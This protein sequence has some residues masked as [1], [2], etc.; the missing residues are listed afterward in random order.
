MVAGDGPD[1]GTVLKRYRLGAGLT[2][3][4]LAER[5]HLSGRAITDLERGVRRA[6]RPDTV[7]LLAEALA[8]APQDRAAFEVAAR[9]H[10]V[11]LAETMAGEA[12]IPPPTTAPAHGGFLG[13]LPTGPLVGR[14]TELRRLLAALDTVADGQGR[15]LLLT[16][17]PGVGKTRLAQ[18]VM[19]QAGERGFRVLAGRCYEQ[20]TSLPFFPFVEALTTGMASASPILHQETPRRFAYLGRLLPDLLES[21]PVREGEDVRLR[22][23]YAVGGFLAALAAEAP[24]ALL[25]DDLHWADSASLE[26]LLHLAR[27][28]A[29]D[30]VLLLGTYR[31]VEVN[32]QHPLE[33][34]LGEL[35]RERLVEEISL[36]GLAVTDTAALIGA[37]FGL[38]EVSGEL[39]D[40]LQART[41]GNPFFIE[42]V[43]KA[44]VE[45]GAIFP[46]GI[47][48][49][50]KAISQ[51][52]VPRSIRSVVGQRV[53]RLAPEA[54]EVLR[55]SSVLGQEW[56]LELLLGA[57]DLDEDAVLRHLAAALAA[58]LLEERRVGRRERYAF[59][60]ALIGQS[61]YAEVPRFRLRK[62]HLRVGTVLERTQGERPE[63]W[64]ELARH[65]LAAGEDQRAT[66]YTLLAG[67]HAAG[68]YAH[69]EA[70]QQYEA[71]LALLQ[72]VGNEIG[73]APVREKLG[74]ALRTLGRYDTALAVL[75][76]VAE[77]YGTAGDL[78]GLARV[79]SQMGL[80]HLLR[81]T[82]EEGIARVQP[83]LDQVE[84]RGSRASLAE[85]LSAFGDL[86]FLSGR[87]S[88]LW[89]LCRRRMDLAG[90]VR[91]DRL[92]ASTLLGYGVML[93]KAGP[94]GTKGRLVEAIGLTEEAGRLYEATG[95]DWRLT[96]SVGNLAYFRAV[97]GELAES[98]HDFQR[99][100][101]LASG[102]GIRSGSAFTLQITAGSPSCWVSGTRHGRT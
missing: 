34:A 10:R 67:D 79:T 91:D 20:Y 27:R 90:I 18:E 87:Y 51:I 11:Q 39:R 58:K 89:D 7:A 78:D 9:L 4:E 65:F 85:M 8:L 52:D 26:L 23:W 48:W 31:D 50:R 21:P 88:E 42:E 15:L 49:D 19:R 68:L 96:V 100:L 40:L 35:V 75:S 30:R 66:R 77:T 44:L 86:L 94:V 81:G 36:R 64:A 29:G 53:G 83:V 73:A 2:Q 61:L 6:P 45:Q 60:H 59:A 57:V 82:G 37:H 13:A 101:L 72:E 95:G 70:V 84:A 25:L 38:A 22:I 32:R 62:V 33:A 41:E 97:S 56:N 71:A 16:G 98:R 5:A 76:Q 14:E 1:F 93:L 63:A 12:G 74:T 102:W 69:A 80:V 46:S 54:Q 24:V 47:G 43:L 3:E 17:E 99:A 28:V 55:V 92:R